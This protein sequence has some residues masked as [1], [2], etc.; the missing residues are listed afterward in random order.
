MAEQKDIPSS[1]LIVG[2][3]VF[4]LGTAYSLTQRHEFRN[5]KITVLERLVFP[6]HDAASIDSSRIVRPDYPDA[7]YST[8]AGEAQK[9][10]RGEFGADERYTEAGLCIV[11]DD[12]ESGA[13]GREY[14]YGSLQNVKE[15]LG[16]T[17]GRRE[18]GGQVTVLDDG[19]AIKE[20]MKNM[21]GNLGR[22]VTRWVEIFLCTATRVLPLHT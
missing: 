11:L 13:G 2:S 20:V 14:M 3:G 18:N 22:Y 12:T 1:V 19:K 5:T 4:G 8:L 6:A 21:D 10:W 17:E 16:L 7:A 15:K 9:I